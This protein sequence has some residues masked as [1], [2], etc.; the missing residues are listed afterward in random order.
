MG[1]KCLRSK[2]NFGP[3]KF[4]IWKSFVSEKFFDMKNLLSKNF[5]SQ[6]MSVSENYVSEYFRSNKTWPLNFLTLSRSS[7]QTP[8]YKHQAFFECDVL[9]SIS[10]NGKVP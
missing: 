5:G 10:C 9:F 2:E 7:Y 3:K 1:L 6:K 8:L 4:C